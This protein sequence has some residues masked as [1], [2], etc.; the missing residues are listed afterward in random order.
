MTTSYPSGMRSRATASEAGPAPTQAMRRPFFSFG[1]SGRKG[2]MS[3]RL[4]AATRFRRQIATGL[5]SMRSRRHAGSQG[6]S[7]VRPRIPGNTFDHQFTM[8][9]SVYRRAAM[10]R[11][12]SGTGVWAGHAH[13]QSTTRW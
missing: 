6:R 4:S 8:Y 5:S 7:Q 12:Y 10:S 1:I 11:M 9:A 13:W 2:E 3:P